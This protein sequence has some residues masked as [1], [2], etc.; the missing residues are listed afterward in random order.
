MVETTCS[1]T[2]GDVV[3]V[4][5][6]DLNRWPVNRLDCLIISATER[7]DIYGEVVPEDN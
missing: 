7:S 1:L 6:C 5:T 4:N 2:C 3:P